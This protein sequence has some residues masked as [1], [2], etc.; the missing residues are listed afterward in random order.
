[1]HA[2][3]DNHSHRPTSFFIEDILL[4]KP[5]SSVLG[6]GGSPGRST[7]ETA[8]SIVSAAGSLFTRPG[9]PAAQQAAS[10]ISSA[11][12]VAAIAAASLQPRMS[13]G[14]PIGAHLPAEYAASLAAYLPGPAAA[15]LHAQQHPF[16][17]AANHPA[18]GPK[19]DHPFLLPAAG[20]KFCF[21][22]IKLGF[23][24]HAKT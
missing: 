15:Y 1:M 10:E 5:K 23:F 22:G 6:T 3:H 21:L 8:A 14:P 7:S 19:P 11:A 2:L 9:A 20:K 16:A 18:F 4:S 13:M 17:A 12:H 24:L